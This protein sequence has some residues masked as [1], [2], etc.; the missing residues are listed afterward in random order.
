M[1]LA[2]SCFQTKLLENMFQ[3]RADFLKWFLVQMKHH[4]QAKSMALSSP[5]SK[6]QLGFGRDPFWMLVGQPCLDF[7]NL[8]KDKQVLSR[9]TTHPVKQLLRTQAAS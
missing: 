4:S 2:V 8:V 1:C 7:N 3:F 6:W 5:R 9:I